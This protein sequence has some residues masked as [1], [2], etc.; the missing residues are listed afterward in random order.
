MQ[1][2]LPL[3]P[4]FFFELYKPKITE[5]KKIL[6]FLIVAI[7]ATSMVFADNIDKLSAG[8]KMFLMKR[9]QDAEDAAK[10][11]GI[12]KSS[13]PNGFKLKPEVEKGIKVG[14]APTEMID[15]V[16]M[17]DAFIYL[18]NTK[19][20]SSLEASGVKV[21]CTFDNFVTA[22]IPV[23]K[24]EE[25]GQLSNVIQIDVSR[26]LK[27][28]TNLASSATNADKS[29]DGLNNGLC[30]NYT[31]EGVIVGVVDQGI[32]F[33][34]TAFN[35][36]DG[37][38]RVKRVYAP[39]K[40]SS[41]YT[42]P[43]KFPDYDVSSGSHG[44]H[45]S[46]TAGG[47]AVTVNGTTYSGMAPES[48]LFLCGLS[49]LSST[50]IANSLDKIKSYATEQN[51]PCVVNIS[52]GSQYGA[53]DGTG[54]LASAYK[55]FTS[56]GSAAGRLICLSAGNEGG[57]NMYY[58]GT[59]TSSTPSCTSL[60]HCIYSD[61]EGTY[62]YYYSSSY[63]SEYYVWPRTSGAQLKFQFVIIDKRSN[64]IV[65][66]ANAVTPST[67]SSSVSLGS[68]YFKNN[69]SNATVSISRSTDSYSGKYYYDITVRGTSTES[70]NDMTTNSEGQYVSRYAV[71]M[72][73][74]SA[75][76]STVQFDCWGDGFSEFLDSKY[77]GT[78]GNY[79]FNNG[80]DECSIGN[81]VPTAGVISVGAYVSRKTV[82]TSNNVSY[83][84]DKYTVGDIA[85]F[86]SYSTGCG[87]DGQVY[88][89][90]TAPGAVLIAGVNK[91]DTS[92]YP[93]S[94]SESTEYMTIGNA[95]DGSRYGS[96]SGTS[97]SAPTTT[98]IMALWLQANP[99]LTANQ[100]K[101]ILNATALRD[102][103]VN[104]TNGAHFGK[105]GKLDAL[106]GLQYIA[107]CD[108][109][110]ITAEP[111]S[112]DFGEITA[113]TSTTKTFTV[114]GENLEG[115]I[116]LA[117][118]GSNY[119]I[120]QTTITKNSN[121]TANATITVTFNAPA[122]TSGTYTGT[123]TLTSSNANS[124]T[125]SL[126]GKGKYN[127]PTM[128]ATPT[129]LSF[130]GT[131][132]GETASKT[133]TVTGSNLQ[134]E[135]TASIS[136]GNGIYSVSPTTITAA[137][138]A[139]GATITVTYA[140]TAVGQSSATVTLSSSNCSPVT[141]NLSGT[142]LGPNITASPESLAFT[143]YTGQSYT[144]TVTVSGNHL[145]NNI[146]ATLSG[147]NIYSID[148]SSLTNAGG[149]ITVTYAPTERGNTSASL[150]LS[151]NGV[152]D[153]IIPIT[154][155]A[156]GGTITANPTNVTFSGYVTKTYTQTVS[157]TGANLEEDIAVTLNDEN[158][159]YSID[160]T[161]ISKT[162]NNATLTI[163]WEPIA[164]G[165]TTAS[166]VL[167]SSNTDNVT[168][169]ITGNAE[170]A[171]PTLIVNP[172]SLTFDAHLGEDDVRSFAITGR[173]ISE[174]VTLT[175]ND[176]RGVFT[177]ATTTIPASS[178]SETE[179][180]NVSLTFNSENEG[181]FT[182]TVTI[183][184]NGA[185]T[186]TVNLTAEASEGGTASDAYLNIAKYATIDEA[187][188]STSNVNNLY[189][190][191]EYVNEDVAWLT[192]PIYGA[193]S[194]C[195]YNNNAQK[196]I[197]TNVTNTTNKYAG[198]SWDSND[199]LLGSANYFTNTTA[200]VMGY[201]SRN[202]TTQE[203]FTFFVTNTTA[204]KMLGLG[205]N[206][207]NSSYPAT[208][209]IY[210]CTENEDG[211]LTPQSN[212]VKS[213]SNSA[214]SGTFVLSATDLDKSKIYK[215]EAATYRS[216]IAEIG[217]QTPINKPTLKGTP[218]EVTLRSKPSQPTSGTVV[219]KGK[220][221]PDNVTLTL[222]DPSGVFEISTQ[223]IGKDDA[224]AGYDVT[225]TLNSD[226]E[227]TFTGSITLTSG[228]LS[229][230]VQLN[231]IVSS[232]GSASDAYLNI[233]KYATIDDAG[234][235][236]SFVNNLYEY[237]EYPDDAC[238][239]LTLPVY[240]AFVGSRYATDNNTISSGQPQ[241]WISTNVNT[242]SNKYYGTS[243]NS[244]E[245]LLG[246]APYFTN[247][248]AR[249]MGYNYRYNTTQE[250]F[251]FFVT[252][253]TAVKL[254]GLGQSTASSSY[255]A[256]L[257]IYECTENADGSLT[258][259]PSTTQSYSN[260]AT[261]GTFVLT[262]TN[263]DEEKIY[264]VEA[265]TYRSYIAEIG[266]QTPLNNPMLKA[267]PSEL[268]MRAAPGETTTATFNVK[269]KM[270][271]GDVDVTLND[272]NNVFSVSTTSISQ[273]NAEAGTDVTVTFRPNVEASYT[274]TITLTCGS[275]SATV[276]LNGYCSDGGTASDAYLNIAKYA[277]IDEAGATVSGM[278][279]IYKYT[280]YTN[281]KCAWLTLSNYGVSQTDAS[282][283]WFNVGGTIK[284]GDETWDSNDIF[285]GN[286]T[287][288]GSSTSHYANWNED[289][290]TFYV[291][292]CT[293]VK[294]YSYN[295]Q[296]SYNTGN[297]YPLKMEIYECTVNADGTLDEGEETVDYHESQLTD[298][299]EIT[300]SGILNASKIYKVR[301]Y[302][303][304][305]HLYEIGF[306]TP[307]PSYTL[308]EVVNRA[309]VVAGNEY[310]IVD[311]DLTAIYASPDG[312]T[313]YCKDDNKFANPS[314]PAEGQVDYIRSHNWQS[315]AWDQS[316]WI[317]LESSNGFSVN[318]LGRQ[319]K[320]VKGVLNDKV[321]PTMTLSVMPEY[322]QSVDVSNYGD[323]MNTFL[324]TNFDPS[325]L[326]VENDYFFVTPK[327]MEVANIKW[328]M[329]DEA[330][331]KFVVA[332]SSN[333]NGAIV[334]GEFTAN[335]SKLESAPVL[336]DDHVYNF[337]GLAVVSRSANSPSG[338]SPRAE[339]DGFVVYALENLVD[340]GHIEDDG[341][342]TDINKLSGYREVVG[343]EYVNA[344][345][346]S[347]DKPFQG[348]NI[349]VT[350]YSD[351]SRSVEKK[352]Y[353]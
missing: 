275:L 306:C 266:F 15:N 212:A 329:W 140:P 40:S 22:K 17:I 302:N 216:Y 103:Y 146:T 193:W 348:V 182:G 247:T 183:A 124:V 299:V 290:Q 102:S 135:I 60:E 110:I 224:E 87:P 229:S 328:A 217:F 227:G 145:S 242:T 200:R 233:A 316:N 251:T 239:W 263:L 136:G 283:E 195:Y 243:W 235:N 82:N 301:I 338:I 92:N 344:S 168:I 141:I 295:I 297:V 291:T 96:M 330:K 116:N 69:S 85:Y 248:T 65:Y 61:I 149:T 48:D 293:Q 1:F 312:K 228:N 104:G 343:V 128:S 351:G 95:S 271:D 112:L 79:T 274:G 16:E 209:K 319:L 269:G 50:N 106:A 214:T 108:Q 327:P 58:G 93:S 280:E 324:P 131:Y 189:K 90:I 265:A 113:G 84:N 130:T 126:T 215:V 309:D 261:S 241:M 188:W 334:D 264:K 307:L 77:A 332:T 51:K 19:N 101:Q 32:H 308:Y 258:A 3:P 12:L 53:H 187:S 134:G 70:T 46:S 254:L 30:D 219:V 240:G 100:V 31:G 28:T 173:F 7:S 125:V 162:A 119:A 246:S 284:T 244:N 205:Q 325:M 315:G 164:T 172:T 171:T 151:S 337:V 202:N 156:Q 10:N 310:R 305:S 41:V 33:K 11:G 37:N 311:N 72:L 27:P 276:N 91:Y 213:E 353:K 221:L 2:L 9:A 303:D 121:G 25:V 29:W 180:V 201:N 160:K 181:N 57:G 74:F 54:S 143:G 39:G 127:A 345:G 208:L 249:V 38:S 194:T 300:S 5:M 129:S 331:Q 178:I 120:S 286:T 137:Q 150:K 98:G 250:T 109:P 43:S 123:I 176:P 159:I 142:A 122:N 179:A 24:I 185:A 350:R 320:G 326:T 80:S 314:E 298:Q 238:A 169:N 118:N 256:T 236:T 292:N 349:V 253:T 198:S 277:T 192:L 186:Q 237:T 287:Y 4:L 133:F 167:S 190:Y 304:Y 175:L 317:A 158:G 153:V 97:M 267:T 279:T 230:V 47:R 294:Q 347:S 68:T 270:L 55:N 341:T 35:D 132:V 152:D 232:N 210:E 218:D 161:T 114:T 67:T 111:T 166:I 288:F 117:L 14:F 94:A 66:T 148:K 26:L 71:G 262:A 64:S 23:D 99:N 18:A 222:N 199:K 204:V 42:D 206:Q 20:V 13:N 36:A 260:S 177:M 147:A 257:K 268:S 282:Q 220:M 289:Y 83:T 34:H 105:Y 115:N 336:Q 278:Q 139:N 76:N 59:A 323:R 272:A 155:T 170:A 81:E 259:S 321:N 62:T 203:T 255:P 285:M 273:A 6:I 339:N 144:K 8:T 211:T 52:L 56:S 75:S 21:M 191:T 73:V 207:A 226:T 184:S 313:L 352:L 223:S 335:F 296:S 78:Y 44:T 340:Q 154:G 107:P 138:A 157:V 234:W 333:V 163:T 342:V 174:D 346:L 165:Q 322:D 225:V 45:T 196:W 86:S 63:Y 197:E 281:D 245:E 231:G 49:S 88:P 89:D 318:Y 252:N